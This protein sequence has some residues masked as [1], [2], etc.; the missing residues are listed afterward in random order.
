[1]TDGLLPHDA[2]LERLR[3]L[4]PILIDLSLG[5][6]QRLLGALGHPETRLPPVI[7]VAGTN[8][9]GSTVAY[10]RA[11]GEAAGLRVHAFTSP[12]LVRF[13]ERIRIAGTLI[14]DDELAALLAQVEAANAGEPITF[15]EITAA[16]ALKAFADT[17]AD[18]CVVEVG[19]GGRYDA[20]NVFEAPALSVITPVDHDHHE[21]LGDTLAK[22]AGEKAGVLKPGRP[23]VIG[24]QPEAALEV[25]EAQATRLG[26]PLTVAGRDFDAYAQGGRMVFQDEAGLLDLP[27]PGLYGAHQVDNAGIAVAAVRALGDPRLDGAAVAAGLV[28][29]RWPARMQR[30][31]AGPLA[32]A[33][34]ARGADLW[35]DGG[36]NPHAARAL[37]EAARSLQARDGR[38]VALIVG[39]LARKDAAGVFEAL[40]GVAEQVCVTGFASEL[41]ADPGVLSEAAGAAGVPATACADVIQAL[42]R[43]LAGEG[44]PP[45][46]IICGSLYLAG[47]VLAMSPATWPT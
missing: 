47:E 34:R 26:S 29:A 21:Y 3:R 18:L 19:L 11:I 39:L 42:A 46:V 14:A 38:P 17:P 20:T 22:I 25:I 27:P 8:G 13:A 32:A 10:L 5:R 35:L 6:V 24:R 30:L 9:K 40:K 15:F 23:A 31:T 1:M 43:V 16:A 2:A 45:H 44:P 36:H 33:A 41:A 28:S 7:H 37:A 4:H 12:H